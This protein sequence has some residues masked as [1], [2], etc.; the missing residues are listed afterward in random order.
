MNPPTADERVPPAN[1]HPNRLLVDKEL[2]TLFVC[3]HCAGEFLILDK[4]RACCVLRHAVYK[5]N[6]EPVPPHASQSEI[7]LL[8]AQNK[9]IGCGGPVRVSGERADPASWTS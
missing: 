1:L 9:V 7:E 4:E 5:T 2:A 3:P 8:V 6:Y